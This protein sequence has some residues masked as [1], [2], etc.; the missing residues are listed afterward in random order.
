MEEF[1]YNFQSVVDAAGS[2]IES[3][4]QEL[5]PEGRRSGANWCVGDI[6][7]GKGQSFQISLKPQN[8]GCYI[9]RADESQKGNVIALVAQKKGMTYQEAGEWLAKRFGVQ[10]EERV[11]KKK[12]KKPPKI[13]RETLTGLKAEAKAYAASRGITEK[14]LRDLKIV[15]GQNSVV[16]PHMD[17]GGNIVMLKY[18]SIDGSKKIWSNESPIST[19]FG[20]HLVDPIKTGGYIIICEGQWDAMTWIQLGYPA[21]SIPS[22]VSNE[23]W[24]EN[25]WVFLNQFTEI[26][27]DFDNDE[28]GRDA[29]SSVKTRLGYDRCKCLRYDAKDANEIFQN[30]K[31]P[32]ILVDALE[33]ARNAPVEHIINAGEIS[34]VVKNLL[35]KSTERQGVPFFLASMKKIEFRPHETTLWFGH[36]GHGKST[37]IMN[38]FAFQASIGIP[39]L[40]ASFEDNSSVNYATLLKQYSCDADVGASPEFQKIYDQLTSMIYLFDSMRR[41]DP[42]QLVATMISAHKQLGICNFAVDNVMTLDVDRQDNTKQAEVADM[43]RV[44]VSKHPVHLHLAAHPRKPPEANIIRPPQ[45]AEVRG[46]SE[47]AD[48]AQN[49]ICVY[50]DVKKAERIEEMWDSKMPPAEI[51]QARE[52][53]PDGRFIIRKQRA[54]GDLPVCSYMFQPL[55]RRFWKDEEDKNCYF[56]EEESDQPF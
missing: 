47:W 25:D 13:D 36:T 19:L 41:T 11:F 53:S 48:M 24:I 15:S 50:R 28:P 14:T 51:Q 56:R 38:Q 29:E 35:C 2:G 27:L 26:F 49:A 3:L 54:T 21:V 33:Q 7:G 18:W 1:Y 20:K 43:F 34:H 22:G 17:M 45:L 39:G 10:P 16:M 5:Y 40:I 46:A 8:A 52:A 42:Q 31:D 6:D 32:K 12:V 37:A 9:D 55:F 44:F 4:C 30:K 23:D